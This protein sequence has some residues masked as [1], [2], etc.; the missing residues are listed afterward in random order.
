MVTLTQLG[1]RIK[2]K[3]AFIVW[4]NHTKKVSGQAIG[5]QLWLAG[6]GLRRMS[7]FRNFPQTVMALIWKYTPVQYLGS[8]LVL[9]RNQTTWRQS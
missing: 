8:V 3:P 2:I 6:F 9:D 1:Y 4:E 7:V 5:T